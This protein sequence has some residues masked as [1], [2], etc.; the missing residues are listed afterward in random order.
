MELHTDPVYDEGWEGEEIARDATH[1]YLWLWQG[2]NIR[3]IAVSVDP[4]QGWSGWD[5]AWCYPRTPALVKAAVA[6]W[7]PDTQHEPA[8]WHKRPSMDFIRVAPAPADTEHN[9]P[10]CEHGSW[11]DD[12]CRT[13]GCNTTA[14]Y[15]AGKG[16]PRKEPVPHGK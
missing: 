5:Y 6:A 13:Y 9:R 11:M 8:G 4:D 2:F 14:A 3:L 12:G 7:D 15:R 1:R 10:R 16:L